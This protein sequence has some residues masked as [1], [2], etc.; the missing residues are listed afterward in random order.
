[1]KK[2]I[3][4]LN[5]IKEDV[6]Y[7]LCLSLFFFNYN[8]FFKINENKYFFFFLSTLILAICIIRLTFRKLNEKNRE[9][10]VINQI[11]IN[12]LKIKNLLLIGYIIFYIYIFYTIVI[13]G[14]NISKTDLY[15]FYLI[16]TNHIFVNIFSL[17]NL[18]IY[19][20]RNLYKRNTKIEYLLNNIKEV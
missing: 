5:F 13:L 18:L 6:I 8:I 14:L 16:N 17:Y 3:K 2:T 7:I 9:D 4:N 20:R 10:F 15:I 1:M 19:K 11:K 12:Y